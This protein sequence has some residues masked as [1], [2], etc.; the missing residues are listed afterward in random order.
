MCYGSGCEFEKSLSGDCEHIENIDGPAPCNFESDE[1]Y[2]E[3]LEIWKNQKQEY[4]YERY[5]D[6]NYYRL[7]ILTNSTY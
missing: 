3:A 6:N 2:Q 5:I 4:D 7:N 1:E